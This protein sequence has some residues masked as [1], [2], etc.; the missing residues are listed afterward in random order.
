MISMK[1]DS[2]LVQ[3]PTW[4]G[5]FHTKL[6]Y[7]TLLKTKLQCSLTGNKNDLLEISYFRGTFNWF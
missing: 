3:H 1:I 2:K 4:R 7:M 5:T 6:K